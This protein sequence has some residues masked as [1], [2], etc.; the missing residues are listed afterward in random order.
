[1]ALAEKFFKKTR[2]ARNVSHFFRK[3]AKFLEFLGPQ[4]QKWAFYAGKSRFLQKTPFWPT[5]PKNSRFARD[6][7]KFLRKT[8]NFAR[9][10]QKKSQGAPKRPFRARR[11]A[12]FKKTRNFA[13]L[14]RKNS[15]VAQKRP[16]RARRLAF[17]EKRA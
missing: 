6:V 7:P 13:R 16:F 9:L 12:F 5:R 2:F 15:R 14:P 3:K 11:F 10:P 17:S 4:R 1:M 8:R